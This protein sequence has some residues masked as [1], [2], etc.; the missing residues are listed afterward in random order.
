MER[1]VRRW[2]RGDATI[3]EALADLAESCWPDWRNM[4]SAVAVTA[5]GSDDA[6]QMS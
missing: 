2:L 3:K 5:G 4:K 1:A 6:S